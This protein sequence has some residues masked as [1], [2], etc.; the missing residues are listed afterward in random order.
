MANLCSNETLWFAMTSLLLM[1]KAR[2][3]LVLGIVPV[4]THAHNGKRSAK[5]SSNL[6][7]VPCIAEQMYKYMVTISVFS[8]TADYEYST[9]FNREV[10]RRS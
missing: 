2:F 8:V 4:W 6:D 9:R 1:K 7:I 10:N 5:V 3:R